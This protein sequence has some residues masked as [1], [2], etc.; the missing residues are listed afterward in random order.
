MRGASVV[1]LHPRLHFQLRRAPLLRPQPIPQHPLPDPPSRSAH[2]NA[3]LKSLPLRQI[4]LQRP[5]TIREIKRI[6][7]HARPGSKM[8]Q[9]SRYSCPKP[10]TRPPSSRI[11]KGGPSSPASV[12]TSAVRA[13][14]SD[15][16]DLSQPRRHFQMR[17]HFSRR[18]VSTNS[19]AAIPPETHPADLPT[20]IAACRDAPSPHRA[21]PHASARPGC[22]SN[23]SRSR[24]KA[25]RCFRLSTASK[26]RD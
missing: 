19:A 17:Q 14:N 11:G 21:R 16:P 18:D 23:D 7:H 6:H 26:L 25:A 10:L 8:P 15:A 12:R 22:D 20:V 24:Y 4:Q 13:A 3:R 5:K 1:C 9:P 2:L